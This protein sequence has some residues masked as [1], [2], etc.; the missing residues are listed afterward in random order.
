MYIVPVHRI[1]LPLFALALSLGCASSPAQ[2]GFAAIGH[3]AIAHELPPVS[4]LR[5][6]SAGSS[7]SGAEF[8]VAPLSHLVSSPGGGVARFTPDWSQ[9][10][11]TRDFA[12]AVYS[13]SGLSSAPDQSLFTAWDP[14]AYPDAGTLWVGLPDYQNGIWLLTQ[15]IPGEALALDS[16][17]SIDGGVSH[18]AI[19]ICGTAQSELLSLRI[20]LA[21]PSPHDECTTGV[22]SILGGYLISRVEP[23]NDTLEPFVWG[24]PHAIGGDKLGLQGTLPSPGFGGYYGDGRIA[25]WSGHEGYFGSGP[26][27]SADDNLFR[28]QLFAWLLDG[29]HRVGFTGAH[30]EWLKHNNASPA[31]LAS[32]DGQAITHG[33]ID[34]ALDEAVLSGYDCVV[35]G[36]PWGALTTS[37]RS[38]LESWVGDGGSLLVLSLG[39]SWG[40][41]LADYAPQQ[42]GLTFGWEI[43]RG[44]IEDADAPNGDTGKPSFAVQPL[45]QYTPAKVVILKKGVD[46]LDSVKL[47]ATNSPGDIYVCEGDYM[48]LQLPSADWPNLSDP[49]AAIDCLDAMYMAQIAMV[50]DQNRPFGGENVWIIPQYAPGAP[51]YMHSGNPIVVIDSASADLVSNFNSYGNPGWGIPHEQGH[52]MH[53]GACGFLFGADAV[54]PCANIF[55]VRTYQ[56]MGW[57]LNQGGHAGYFDEGYAYHALPSPNYADM[58]ASAWVF[59]GLLDLIWKKYGW[60][61]MEAFLA[62]AAADTASGVT[63]PDD[64]FKCAYLVENLSHKYQLD[65]SPLFDHW[66]FPLA[67]ATRAITDV[68]P[69][70]DIPW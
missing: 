38:A 42:L 56:R 25:I 17:A 28:Q 65:L 1:L 63:A 70:A 41:D 29:R 22:T 21:R 49:A 54:E 36:N 58:Q 57:D 67:D 46:D 26:D 24:G 27:A 10:R 16:A 55:T 18:A 61:A 11:G 60:D 39:W 45:T 43:Q 33:S 15:A 2:G 4:A 7:L 47:L 69:D 35:I 30:G 40:G 23:L 52:N 31:L 51:W 44:T 53:L 3:A 9:S 64:A 50:G 68:Y 62:Q 37:E 20:G 5:Q 12:F 34:S 6:A 32:M 48:G 66:D 14:S 8:Q 13:F 59:L 19:I